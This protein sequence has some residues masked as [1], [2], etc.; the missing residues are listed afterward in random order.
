MFSH[1]AIFVC[2]GAS[3]LTVD[4]PIC[5]T[6]TEKDEIF[7]KMV[8][9]ATNN[10]GGVPNAPRTLLMASLAQSAHNFKAADKIASGMEGGGASAAV[11]DLR[12]IGPSALKAIMEAIPTITCASGLIV[13]W[14]L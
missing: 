14:L 13:L 9:V 10:E 3:V 8:K 6:L 4:N 7:F 1:L 2:V 5:R 11:T 12:F